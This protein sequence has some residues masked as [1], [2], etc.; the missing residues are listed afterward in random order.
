[1]S[2]EITATQFKA[3]CLRLLDEVARSGRSLTITKHGKPVARLEPAGQ[4]RALAG[5][6]QLKLSDEELISATM[7]PWDVEGL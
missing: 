1:M 4:R 5:S 2:T 6:A 7:G 3:R